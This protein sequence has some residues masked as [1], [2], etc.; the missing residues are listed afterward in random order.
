MMF[1][2]VGDHT[3]RAVVGGVMFVCVRSAKETD[4][5]VVISWAAYREKALLKGD[6]RTLN[7]A[8]ALC[9]GAMSAPAD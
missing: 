7:E 9:R 2:I 4:D 1:R 8:K 6:C 3:H 5:G